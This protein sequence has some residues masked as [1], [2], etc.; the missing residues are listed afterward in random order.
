MSRKNPTSVF[1]RME[2]VSVAAL[3]KHP[4]WEDHIKDIPGVPE[5]LLEIERALI[6]EGI[7]GNIANEAWKK[8]KDAGRLRDFGHVFL[9][10][11]PSDMVVGRFWPSS[12]AKKRQEYPMVVCAQCVGQPLDWVMGRALDRLKTLEE[13]CRSTTSASVVRSCVESATQELRSVAPGGGGDPSPDPG[14]IAKVASR[15]EMGGEGF[16]RLMYQFEEELAG[17]MQP[18]LVARMARRSI[19]TRAQHLRVPACADSPSEAA[20][21][22]LRFL[23]ARL[24][25]HATIVLFMPIG[26]GW[27]DVVVGEPTPAQIYCLRAT[28]EALP[29]ASEIPYSFDDAFR[30]RVEAIIAGGPAS[31]ARAPKTTS[32]SATKPGGSKKGLLI[33]GAAVVVGGIALAGYLATRPSPVPG[34]TPPV[35]PTPV[36][37]RVV[38]PMVQRWCEAWQ[39]TGAGA[40][41]SM[42]GEERGALS[43]DGFLRSTLLERL[44]SLDPRS[45]L[46]AGDR[47]KP[48]DALLR[49]APEGWTGSAAEG[50]SRDAMASLEGLASSLEAWPALASADAA[51]KEMEALGWAKAAQELI[52]ARV[53]IE[54]RLS[55]GRLPEAGAMVGLV[56]GLESAGRA[57]ATME[58]VEALSAAARGRTELEVLADAFERGVSR[59]LAGVGLTGL[60]EAMEESARAAGSAAAFVEGSWGQVDA[61]TFARESARHREIVGDVA[62]P[63]ALSAWV[64]EA[65]GYMRLSEPENPAAA[66]A[67]TIA[68]LESS[69][70]ARVDELRAL[71]EAKSRALADRLVRASADLAQAREIPALVKHRESIAQRIRAVSNE[72]G[73]IEQEGARLSAELGAEMWLPTRR[74]LQE[75]AALDEVVPGE[76][77]INAEWRRL[78]AMILGTA[79]TDPDVLRSTPERASQFLRE[80]GKLRADLGALSL[81]MSTSL[82]G[83]VVD[84][85]VA[86]EVQARL[87]DERERRLGTALG[88][89]VWDGSEISWRNDP[90]ERE[91]NALGES[92]SKARR[93]V[94]RLALVTRHLGS[95]RG[96]DDAI[97]GEDTRA[98]VAACREDPLVTPAGPTVAALLARVEFLEELGGASRETLAALARDADEQPAEVA[99]AVWRG[100]GVHEWPAS[101]AELALES[102]LRGRL[103]GLGW[104]GEAL[105]TEGPRRWGVFMASASDADSIT[106]GLAAAGSMGSSG[107]ASLSGRARFNAELVGLQQALAGRDLAGEDGR[108]LVEAFVRGSEEWMGGMGA[109]EAAGARAIVRALAEADASKP[110]APPPPPEGVGPARA[111]W[112][113]VEGE[114]HDVLRYRARLRGTVHELTFLRVE[115]SGAPAAYVCTEEMSVGLLTDLMQERRASSVLAPLLEHRPG[116]RDDRPGPRSWEWVQGGA[117]V[118][119]R[120]WLAFLGTPIP[121][122]TFEP[123]A[124]PSPRMPAQHLSARGAAF[125]AVLAGCRFPTEPEWKAALAQ[126]RGSA[127]NEDFARLSGANLLDAKWMAQAAYARD[128]SKPTP[129]GAR[130]G[131]EGVPSEAPLG[132]GHDDGVV[133]F[134]EVGEGDGRFKNLIGNVWEFVYA[135]TGRLESIDAG[136]GLTEA[137]RAV[138]GLGA[139]GWGVIGGSGFSPAALAWEASHPVPA[140]EAANRLGYCDVGVRLAF[141][142]PRPVVAQ[143]PE[144]PALMR[145]VKEARVLARP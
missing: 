40:M 44:P 58:R 86:G 103:A 98:F 124:G 55:E 13:Q 90:R 21:L 142:A 51:G 12:D 56:A 25:R 39:L 132:A 22:W 82:A 70:R 100:L 129:E 15:P 57:S 60:S 140:E 87:A 131:G 30:R 45:L 111:G 28:P 120:V 67:S 135:D 95:G 93:I 6:T 77:K 61:E 136:K 64:E 47:G 145:V 128:R 96:L 134:R 88:A 110:D 1:G 59:T 83:D 104:L 144:R 78:R 16:L 85:Q 62:T 127:S 89:L 137:A 141:T 109:D 54:S 41:S 14:V 76:A 32:A 115:P 34:P 74:A 122:P 19:E 101:S 10:R 84:P 130:F 114:S 68:A 108:R 31:G 29:V 48:I 91:A 43:S 52:E 97:D 20:A 50:R 26:Q 4:G 66:S 123:I 119:S 79:M 139:R 9:W 126:D 33:A 72:L 112:T 35:G 24:D 118:V 63:A 105:A 46:P 42:T 125:A 80:L 11:S 73:A 69:A 138:D 99:V 81:R 65:K 53:R 106:A 7:G 36:T 121:D 5:R 75:V 3:G 143:G 27:V 2:T 71:D 133:F 38:S 18:D 113:Q 17:F 49:E 23:L 92:V 117:M 94:D 116:S 107:I 37:D 102:A 8:L